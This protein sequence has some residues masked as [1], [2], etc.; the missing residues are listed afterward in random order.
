MTTE[1]QTSAANAISLRNVWK[2]YG[3][4][5][6]FSPGRIGKFL[7]G[8]FSAFRRKDMT[9][10]LKDLSLDVRRGE[11]LGV[12][13]RNGAGKSTLLKIISGVSKA[14]SGKVKVSGSIF[15]M[16]ELSAG[17]NPRFTGRENIYLLAAIMN[18][19]KETID[20]RIADIEEF[21][22][23]GEF[24]DRPVREYSSGMPGRLGFSVAVHADA[25][26]V[27]IDEVLSVGDINFRNRCTEKMEELR[28]SGKTIVLVS[29]NM[30]AISAL[31]ARTV[32]IE[33][34]RI[35]YDGITANAVAYYSEFMQSR[36]RKNIEKHYA[37]SA[38]K[39]A[40]RRCRLWSLRVHDSAVVPTPELDP[41]ESL[42]VSFNI[43]FKE[44]VTEVACQVKITDSDGVAVVDEKA[45]I[46]M[47]A[48]GY[49]ACEVK[50][51]FERGLPLKYGS[52]V[53][54]V[55]IYDRFATE[56]LAEAERPISI[57]L[58]RRQS[59]GVISPAYRVEVSKATIAE[60]PRIELKTV[61]N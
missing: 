28:D 13:G 14:N 9:M 20:A 31:C 15:P 11:L 51:N 50:V 30:S 37:K 53:V 18:V 47:N 7:T 23:L 24:F 1:V 46:N 26:I 60:I 21:C 56:K 6:A 58:N 42:I 35:E 19:S 57:R 22:D 3:L 8:D 29:H 40:L 36:V 4:P 5:Y 41:S 59:D 48:T 33:N 38:R 44:E 49:E 52:Y 43:G 32:V 61:Q 34:G 45:I 25:D 27:L 54:A 17:M 12:I 39:S 16:I 10:V 55:E 2:A